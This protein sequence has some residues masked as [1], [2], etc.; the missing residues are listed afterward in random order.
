MLKIFLLL[1]PVVGLVLIL[2]LYFG[3]VVS[4]GNG[5]EG[6]TKTGEQPTDGQE[7][8]TLLASILSGSINSRTTA[9]KILTDGFA[10]N[11]F[12][13]DITGV[14]KSSSKLNLEINLP[15]QDSFESQK[16]ISSIRCEPDKTYVI[17]STNLALI[18]NGAN[19]IESA[20]VGDFLWAYCLDENCSAVGKECVLSKRE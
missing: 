18:Q 3:S 5:G 16:T 7:T 15:N 13:A 2:Y 6:S 19:L 20:Q 1:L 11:A 17:S 10:G 9:E 12:F 4:N 14:D 8:D